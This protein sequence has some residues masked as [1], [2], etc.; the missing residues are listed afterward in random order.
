MGL[1]GV[2]SKL[3][4]HPHSEARRNKLV[5]FKSTCLIETGLSRYGRV[6]MVKVAY[7]MYPESFRWKEPPYG[8]STIAIHLT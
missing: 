1:P 7:D 2:S 6:A 3:R 8:T 4:F 5:A